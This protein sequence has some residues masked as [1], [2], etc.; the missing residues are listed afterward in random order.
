MAQS[1]FFGSA[2]EQLFGV[3]HPASKSFSRNAVVLCGTLGQEQMRAHRSFRRLA[4][5]LAAAG[6][7]VLRFDYLGTGDSAGR[8]E[9]TSLA[10]CAA[11]IQS[12]IEE[13]KAMS[14]ATKITLVGL[15]LGAGLAVNVAAQRSDVRK[16]ILWDPVYDGAAYLRQMEAAHKEMLVDPGRFPVP[17]NASDA[18]AEE[19]NGYYF[20]QALR[21]DILAIQPDSFTASL[22]AQT[23]IIESSMIAAAAGDNAPSWPESVEHL[24]VTENYSW[25][26]GE[27][28]EIAF[29]PVNLL[30]EISSRIGG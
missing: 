11:N 9:D 28:V 22:P 13:L 18:E 2:A 12:A 19:L 15:R 17:R 1:I 16:L 5:T 29:M 30:G 27:E 10:S 14:S 23:Q 8:G 21:S 4:L 20:S 26:R 25:Q 24:V 3:Y 6:S 7:H